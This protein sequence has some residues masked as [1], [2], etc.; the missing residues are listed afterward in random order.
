MRLPT[1]DKQTHACALVFTYRALVCR[2]AAQC[3]ELVRFLQ[4][5]DNFPLLDVRVRIAAQTH[6]LVRDS[7][8]I[9]ATGRRPLCSRRG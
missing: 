5:V 1:C 3:T 2:C 4:L 6:P 8:L 7:H 9:N